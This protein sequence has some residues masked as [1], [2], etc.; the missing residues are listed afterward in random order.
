M[1]IRVRVHP[2]PSR[3]RKLSSLLPTILGWRRPGK[4]G[5]ANT[6]R[7]VDWLSSFFVLLVNLPTWL[8]ALNCR[9][10]KA[11]KSK[12]V[13]KG[14]D[15]MG[16]VW[17]SI[18]AVN[19]NSEHKWRT[20]RKFEKTWKK[21]LTNGR[22]SDILDNVPLKRRVPCKLNNETNEKHQKVLKSTD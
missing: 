2:F 15:K 5:S 20:T 17:Y 3:T 14:V 19:E 7:R 1:L 12:N 11:K 9:K 16:L 18:W 13:E 6:A 21:C 10:E 8:D 4:I 22:S